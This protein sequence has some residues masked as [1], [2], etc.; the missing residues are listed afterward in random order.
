MRAM[1]VGQQQ[2]RRQTQSADGHRR[3]RWYLSPIT[4][5]EWP[6]TPFRLGPPRTTPYEP[7]QRQPL[8]RK[9]PGELMQSHVFPVHSARGTGTGNSKRLIRPALGPRPALPLLPFA[10]H[11]P[12]ALC[13]PAAWPE[14]PLTGNHPHALLHVPPS[15]SSPSC[16][17]LRDAVARWTIA[18]ARLSKLHLR[19]HGD[20]KEE[21]KVGRRC[22]WPP[23]ERCLYRSSKWAQTASHE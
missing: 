17:E 14:L 19:E 1:R 23:G 2:G 7:S 18:L 22:R 15:P 20:V 8:S 5:L 4:A 16:P 21:V 12:G 10:P 11:L 9:A 3:T 13:P 6:C